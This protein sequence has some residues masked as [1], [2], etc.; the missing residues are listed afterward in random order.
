MEAYFVQFTR[1]WDAR[2]TTGGQRPN[3]AV[4]WKQLPLDGSLSAQILS[5]INSTRLRQM[6]RPRPVPP[7]SL[8]V[9]PST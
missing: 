5:S 6:A 8:V 2:A 9:D 3:S 1:S 7:Y 4:N